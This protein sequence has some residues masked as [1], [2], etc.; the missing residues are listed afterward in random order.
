MVLSASVFRNAPTALS[1]R[2]SADR[3]TLS[4]PSPVKLTPACCSQ[5][6]RIAVAS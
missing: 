4:R 5:Y 1:A 2:S 3:K 6:P